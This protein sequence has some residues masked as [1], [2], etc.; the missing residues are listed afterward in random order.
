M[1]K[2]HKIIL[3]VLPIAAAIFFGLFLYFKHSAEVAKYDFTVQSDKGDVKL[4][5]FRGK[6]TLV[7]FGYGLCPDICPTTLYAIA[8]GLN[9]LTPM[10]L[11][12]VRVV[13]ISVDPERDKPQQLGVFARYFHQN[14]IGEMPGWENL[15]VGKSIDLRNREKKIIAE[16]KNKYNTMNSSSALAIYDK[17]QRHLDYDE[18]YKGFTAYCVVIIPKSPRS[19]NITFHPSERGTNRPE[20][21]NIRM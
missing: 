11:D 17:L 8:E 16:I 14:I 5:D 6:K 7:Y 1:T 15:K 19:L 18:S 20:R 12:S 10:E 13:F 4:A 2:T 3:S 9:K 21:E